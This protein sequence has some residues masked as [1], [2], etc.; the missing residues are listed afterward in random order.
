MSGFTS[1]TLL[2]R[3]QYFYQFKY[4]TVS[5]GIA[6]CI[7]EIASNKGEIKRGRSL[8]GTTLEIIEFIWGISCIGIISFT[9]DT[10]IVSQY[11]K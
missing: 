5:Y 4:I 6:K 2:I 8:K 11:Q 1:N 7:G 10:N 3:I 9:I